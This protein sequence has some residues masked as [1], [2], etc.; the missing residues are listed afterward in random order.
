MLD[1]MDIVRAF[2]VQRGAFDSRHQ[3]TSMSCSIA[4][5]I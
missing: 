1:D 2:D 3:R 4:I 5:L